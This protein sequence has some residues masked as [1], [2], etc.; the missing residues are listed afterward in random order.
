MVNTW[1]VLRPTG[2]TET[3]PAA[4]APGSLRAALEGGHVKRDAP[5]DVA[6]RGAGHA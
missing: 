3:Q 1:L 5:D 2:S 4:S 6:L